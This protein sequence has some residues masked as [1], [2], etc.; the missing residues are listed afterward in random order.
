[1]DF[2]YLCLKLSSPLVGEGMVQF[3]SLALLLLWKAFHRLKNKQ[4]LGSVYVSTCG[5]NAALSTRGVLPAQT[6][7]ASSCWVSQ[8]HSQVADVCSH[9]AVPVELWQGYWALQMHFSEDCFGFGWS[10]QQCLQPKHSHL[11]SLLVHFSWEHSGGAT[12]FPNFLSFWAGAFF[13][14]VWFQAR[15]PELSPDPPWAAEPRVL[16][17][18][19]SPVGR[20]L[21]EQ[22][23][24][25]GRNVGPIQ[26]GWFFFYFLFYL[27]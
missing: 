19:V 15:A 16:K 11:P 9:G 14:G 2:I 23:H 5:Y 6:G 24:Y 25:S 3:Y 20:I 27:I 21:L 1:M 10:T 13:A 22:G 4:D 7:F 18:S 17:L 26:K 12:V 8:G